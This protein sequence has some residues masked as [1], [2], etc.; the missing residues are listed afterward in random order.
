[1]ATIGVGSLRQF[2]EAAQKLIQ[3][4]RGLHGVSEEQTPLP[5]MLEARMSKAEHD[6]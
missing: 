1:M 3:I 6:A 4:V 5:E 2:D